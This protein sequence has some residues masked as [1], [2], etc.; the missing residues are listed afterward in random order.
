MAGSFGVWLALLA[1]KLNPAS[2]LLLRSTELF[3]QALIRPETSSTFWV[4][5]DCTEGEVREDVRA[6]FESVVASFVTHGVLS[7]LGPRAGACP[8]VSEAWTCE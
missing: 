5:S 8:V 1:F 6:Y 4:K 3:S 2:L 7:R